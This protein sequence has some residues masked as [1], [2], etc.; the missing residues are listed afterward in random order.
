MKYSLKAFTLVELIVAITIIA[1]LGTIGISSFIRN[2]GD[3]RDAIRI[4]D[5]KSLARLVTLQINGEKIWDIN[6]L[7]TTPLPDNILL[8]GEVYDGVDI[9]SIGY[10]VGE[11]SQFKLGTTD[12]LSDPVS[13][14]VY[15]LAVVRWIFG[16]YFQIAA[17]LEDDRALVQGNYFTMTWSDLSGIIKAYDSNN[18]V[19]DWGSF[20]PY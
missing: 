2:N 1:I 12:P 8:S 15:P 11:P 16:I 7:I 10:I 14:D 6:N 20:L 19:I 5:T 18:P 17:K 3:A 4:S 13:A 9:T